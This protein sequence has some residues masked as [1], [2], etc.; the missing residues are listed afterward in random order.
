V[1]GTPPGG[2]AFLRCVDSMMQIKA[3]RCIGDDL[4]GNLLML[5][6]NLTLQSGLTELV[7][8]SNI[9]R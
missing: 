7:L 6:L 2:G 4:T 1:Q 5:N 8:Y 9:G 3:L